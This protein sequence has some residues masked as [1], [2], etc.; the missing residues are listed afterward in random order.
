M[1]ILPVNQST[2]TKRPGFDRNTMRGSSLFRSACL[3]PEGRAGEKNRGIVS[4]CVVWECNM[5]WQQRQS[6]GELV[7]SFML[8]DALG[9]RLLKRLNGYHS[10]LSGGACGTGVRSEHLRRLGFCIAVE[11][12]CPL[13]RHVSLS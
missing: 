13:T 6:S 11:E 1:D 12:D 9:V 4:A 7:F 10:E 3:L 2:S 8:L 5:T